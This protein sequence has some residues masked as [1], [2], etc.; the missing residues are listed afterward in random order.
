MERF[1]AVFL[2]MA[3]SLACSK[4]DETNGDS[5]NNTGEKSSWR[6]EITGPQQH[7]FEGSASIGLSVGDTTVAINV[8][9]ISDSSA[10]NGFGEIEAAGTFNLESPQGLYRA[11]KLPITGDPAVK[12]YAYFAGQVLEERSL[13]ALAS[14]ELNITAGQRGEYIEATYSFSALLNNPS[15][16]SFDTVQVSGSFEAHK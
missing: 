12:A 5:P 8:E 13:S 6:M 11:Q 3:V 7:T 2:L 10:N 9:S 16:T 4:E 14:G 1:I 15:N